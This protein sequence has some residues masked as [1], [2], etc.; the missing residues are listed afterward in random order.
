MDNKKGNPWQIAAMIGTLGTEIVILTI[1]G[2]WLGNRMD[3]AWDTKP[4]MLLAGVLIGL[5]LGFVSA[6][7]TIKAFTKE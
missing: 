4:F 2:A 3:T 6:G 7:Y 1:A 5:V